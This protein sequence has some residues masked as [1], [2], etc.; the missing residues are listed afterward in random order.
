MPG[1]DR[2]YPNVNEDDWQLVPAHI[3]AGIADYVQYGQI[4]GDFL[5]GVICNDLTK[6]VFHADPENY[7]RLG[8]IAKFIYWHTPAPCQGSEEKM[9]AWKKLGG[10]KGLEDA[11][12]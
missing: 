9:L 5:Q 12:S 1:S 8:D 6:A 11:K 2:V 3:R 10:L 4:P 7:Q